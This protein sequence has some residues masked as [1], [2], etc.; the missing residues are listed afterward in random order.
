MG[1]ERGYQCYFADATNRGL[2]KSA[3]Q[4]TTFGDW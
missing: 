4:A 1:P 3:M 2:I